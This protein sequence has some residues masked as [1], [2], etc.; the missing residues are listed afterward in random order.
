ME[1]WSMRCLCLNMRTI[2]SINNSYIWKWKMMCD[3]SCSKSSVSSPIRYGLYWTQHIH[4]YVHYYAHAMYLSKIVCFERRRTFSTWASRSCAPVTIFKSTCRPIRSCSSIF[5]NICVCILRQGRLVRLWVR[6]FFSGAFDPDDTI[7]IF[8]LT[9]V[10]GFFTLFRRRKT[11]I[12]VQIQSVKI[13]FTHKVQVWRSCFFI[14]VSRCSE[15]GDATAV[16]VKGRRRTPPVSL[17]R[18][19]EHMS[20]LILAWHFAL[21]MDFHW[22]AIT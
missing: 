22:L 2:D 20:I 6:L 3:V 18:K 4:Y 10:G 16:C 8:I 19:S 11:E 17:S 9:L 21:L 12:A 7:K 5:Y 14:N 13:T 1:N 15:A